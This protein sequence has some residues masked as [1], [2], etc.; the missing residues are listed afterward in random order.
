[1]LVKKLNADAW[2]QLSD[3]QAVLLMSECQ[4]C[5]KRN[6][7]PLRFCPNCHTENPGKKEMSRLGT[8]YSFSR[9]HVPHKLYPAPYIVGYVDFPEGLRV[10]GQIRANFEDVRIGM[11]VA[12]SVCRFG[13]GEEAVVAYCFVPAER[14]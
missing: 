3:D 5:G 13:E 4:H 1:M 12:T 7:P 8:L 9:V 10:F 14:E 6:F 2:K 11:K